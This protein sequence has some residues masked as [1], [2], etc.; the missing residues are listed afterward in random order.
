MS[1]QGVDWYTT[2]FPIYDRRGFLITPSM[3][4]TSVPDALVAVRV[5]VV[6]HNDMTQLISNA[7]FDVQEVTIL[8]TRAERKARDEEQERVWYEE[9]EKWLAGIL[10]SCP[11]SPVDSH[12]PE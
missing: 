12:Y 11:S 9:R 8:E 3:Y 4:A 7:Y 5:T 1:D 6:R 2:P 10:D